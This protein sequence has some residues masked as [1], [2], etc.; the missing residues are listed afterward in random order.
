M[1][2]GCSYDITDP[3][4]GLMSCGNETVPGSVFC[5]MHEARV[6]GLQALSDDMDRL[7][8]PKAN[9][10]PGERLCGCG[11]R[12]DVHVDVIVAGT[13]TPPGSTYNPETD[14]YERPDGTEDPGARA[15]RRVEESSG[16]AFWGEP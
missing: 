8:D 14:R 4:H 7:D 16:P 12:H 1:I 11:A 2:D 6:A 5:P 15:R 9:D 3:S 13:S 10:R